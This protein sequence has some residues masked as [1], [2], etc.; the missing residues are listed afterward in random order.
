[1]TE[2]QAALLEQAH[3]SIAAAGVLLDA[4]YAGFAASRAYYAMFYAARA[5]RE[6]EGLSFSKHS[7]VIAAFGQHFARTGRLP[8]EH[9][10]HFIQAELVRRE[11][12]YGVTSTV[13]PDQ[14]KE[15]LARADRFVALAEQYLSAPPDADP[16]G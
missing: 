4:G 6:G 11:G 3:Q 2:D 15:T 16:A 1:M 14:V 8:A 7:A 9:H 5:L 10:R 12:D 13:T